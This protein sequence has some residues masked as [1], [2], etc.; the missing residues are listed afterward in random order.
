MKLKHIILS[1]LILTALPAPIMASST[2]TYEEIYNK[3]EYRKTGRYDVDKYF[4]LADQ[5]KPAYLRKEIK[6]NKEFVAKIEEKIEQDNTPELNG[7]YY[8]MMGS[9]FRARESM[10]DLLKSVHKD[11]KKIEEVDAKTCPIFKKEY[12]EE[13][14][15]KFETVIN[16]NDATSLREFYGQSFKSLKAEILFYYGITFRYARSTPIYYLSIIYSWILL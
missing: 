10:F 15:N 7:M 14:I 4:N 11:L 9:L 13:A 2:L 1:A 5:E 8:A 16:V 3:Y 6:K 12:Y